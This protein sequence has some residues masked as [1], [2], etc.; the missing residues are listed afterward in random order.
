MTHAFRFTSGAI[1][2]LGAIFST[3]F[4][5]AQNQNN[6]DPFGGIGGE[7][8]EAPLV[9]AAAA[10][11]LAQPGEPAAIREL[12]LPAI[13]GAPTGVPD[14]L[15]RCV[16]GDTSM[17]SAARIHEA[18]RSPLREAGLDFTD[19]PLEE[20]ITFLQQ[21]Y[22]IPTRFDGAALKDASI[23]ADTPTTV[24]LHGISLGAAL[25][26]MLKELGLTYTIHDE[27]LLIT[28]P[29]AAK[30][31]LQTCVYDIRDLL[32][33][34][35]RGKDFDAI[36]D[37]IV[38]CIATESW[39]ENGGYE[40]EIRPLDPGFLIISQTQ[41]VHDEIRGLL[42]TIR[43]LKAHPI[44]G[45]ASVAPPSAS[46]DEVVTQFYRLQFGNSAVTDELRNQVRDLIVKGLPEA[47][48]NGKLDSGQSVAVQ[49]LNDRV[50]VRH[51][52]AVQEMVEE[53][54]ADSGIL[55]PISFGGVSGGTDG[56]TR[57]SP[58]RGNDSREPAN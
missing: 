14:D 49:V 55:R 43:Q 26:L 57:P 3:T 30:T 5:V 7:G 52:P 44:A 40:A 9:P 24:N 15:C 1:L 35:K 4:A 32:K 10:P 46:A 12:A 54:L 16:G 27:V 33:D 31:Q 13:A 20:A 56:V 38:A 51:K 6:A 28:T 2:A 22:G 53:L 50:V 45:A 48:W 41:T 58:S 21:E 29:D 47:G 42:G 17:E 39:A 18:L 8:V 19:A 23:Q 25:R 36:I 11:Q 34:T 37:S